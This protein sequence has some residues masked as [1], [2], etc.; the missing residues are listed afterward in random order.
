MWITMNRAIAMK[1][2]KTR[3]NAEADALLVELGNVGRGIPFLV[4]Y[5]AGGGE[6]MTFDGPI[7]QQQVLDA[8]NRAGPSRP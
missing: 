7:L 1:A 5:P 3:G 2:D 6:P 8:L 4:V